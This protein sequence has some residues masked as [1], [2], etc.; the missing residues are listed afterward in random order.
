MNRMLLGALAGV[1]AGA[2]VAGGIGAY[3]L[4]EIAL[5]LLTPYLS[6]GVVI[7]LIISIVQ[8]VTSI[9]DQTLTFVPKIL[10][11]VSVAAILLFVMVDGWQLIVGSLLES[12][13]TGDAVPASSSAA[14]AG[15]LMLC[16]VRRPAAGRNKGGSG[17]AL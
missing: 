10:V 8:S 7:G 13:A 16:F 14:A 11:M 2:L 4:G 1:P 17:H 5:P 12:F 9:Q 6:A 3:L 15:L